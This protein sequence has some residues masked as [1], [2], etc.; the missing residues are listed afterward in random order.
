MLNNFTKWLAPI[1]MNDPPAYLVFEAP[2]PPNKM[3]GHTTA[4]I[5]RLLHGISGHIESLGWRFKVRPEE[6]TVSQIRSWALG[7]NMKS[8]QAK[9]AVVA[10]AQSWGHD[11]QDDNAAD[12]IM[13]HA[14]FVAQHW[15]DLGRQSQTRMFDDEL[16]PP[17]PLPRG[18]KSR[19][20]KNQN[21]GT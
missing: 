16:S 21:Q 19:L 20:V 11:P 18:K 12:A 7:Y 15:P 5:F 1:L 10:L 4:D 3:F 6:H 17:S 14:Y 2:L 8:E 13:L 9:K